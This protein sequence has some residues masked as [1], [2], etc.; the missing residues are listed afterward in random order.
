[1]QLAW[2]R[3]AA[4]L[5][6]NM[7]IDNYFLTQRLEGLLEIGVLVLGALEQDLQSYDVLKMTFRQRSRLVWNENTLQGHQ[8]RFRDQAQSMSLFLQAIQL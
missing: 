3:I 2:D 7:P 1:M 6:S 5:K 4:W 8:N